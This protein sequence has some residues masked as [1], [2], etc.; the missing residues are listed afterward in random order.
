LVY[1]RGKTNT[2]YRPD[3][4]RFNSI[5]GIRR[6][7]CKHSGECKLEQINLANKLQ[8][9]YG[10]N[11]SR[12][13]GSKINLPKDTRSAKTNLQIDCANFVEMA[14]KFRWKCGERKLRKINVPNR[15]TA[16]GY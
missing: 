7:Q 14:I 6:S 3:S 8:T 9:N 5:Y 16:D 2:A 10:H 12:N 1:F 13:N 4:R 11:N 15:F